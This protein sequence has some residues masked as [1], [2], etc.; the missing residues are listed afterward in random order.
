M[1]SLFETMINFD[2]SIYGEIQ[3]DTILFINRLKE[4]R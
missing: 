2:L 1:E 3:Q 4:I